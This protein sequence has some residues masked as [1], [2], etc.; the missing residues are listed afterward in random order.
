MLQ[1]QCGLRYALIFILESLL[2]NFKN[3]KHKHTLR[4][5]LKKGFLRIA[6]L[7]DF[8]LD[9]PL[10]AV[11]WQVVIAKSLSVTLDAH[12][13]LILGISVWLCYSADRFSEPRQVVAMS[14]RRYEI[15]KKHK[16][17]FLVIWVTLLLLALSLSFVVLPLD[18]FFWGVPLFVLSV[19]N[20]ALCLRESHSG[21]PSPVFKELRTAGILALG[22]F[23]FPAY[24]SSPEAM[25][26][27]MTIVV[28]FYLLFI[29]CVSVSRWELANDHRR[30]SLSFL[31]RTPKLLTA[32]SRTKLL[33]A[34][35]LGVVLASGMSICLGTFLLAHALTIV[36]FV[37]W[38]DEI[39]FLDEDEKRK[40][41]DQG[42]WVL[43]LLMLSLDHAGLF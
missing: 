22:C 40:V 34:L 15:Y 12:H 16:F 10:V 35:A 25:N 17:V 6:V 24:E 20:L 30:G 41:I 23:F 8:S 2:S 21:I 28:L 36:V 19:A 11:A 33:A 39:S 7:N 37:L 31:Q 4:F 26:S 1:P 5:R 27:S 29:N 32:L 14:S 43:P 9:A 42:Y 13:H 38:L 18:C 3:S